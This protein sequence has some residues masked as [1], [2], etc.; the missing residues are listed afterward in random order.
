MTCEKHKRNILL[1]TIKEKESRR[2]V[3]AE[4]NNKQR[5]IDLLAEQCTELGK[6][7]PKQVKLHMVSNISAFT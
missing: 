5:Q 6:D 7:A 1:W 2:S 4:K 3:Q